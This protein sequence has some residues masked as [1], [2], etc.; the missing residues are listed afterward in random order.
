PQPTRPPG[1]L[2]GRHHPRVPARRRRNRLRAAALRRRPATARRSQHD[3]LGCDRTFRPRRRPEGMNTTPTAPG[4][5]TLTTAGVEI[6]YRVAGR[7]PLLVLHPPGWGIGAT[8]YTTTLSRL[9]DA[10]TVVY[11]W[12]R[13]AAGGPAPA[14]NVRLDI[15]AFVTDLETL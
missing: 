10:F 13:G 4:E 2:P 15:P 5:H 11:L 14:P 1:S 7:G 9:E 3:S 6:R 12:P 8:P